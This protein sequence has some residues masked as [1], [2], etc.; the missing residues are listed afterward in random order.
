MFVVVSPSM[1]TSPTDC[2]VAWP[3]LW[4]IGVANLLHIHRL[5]GLFLVPPP[6]LALHHSN[7]TGRLVLHAL[8]CAYF[9][10]ELRE[11]EGL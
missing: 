5:F 7:P 1:H 4:P 11:A 2:G 3:T 10:I 6:P 8:G 9:S